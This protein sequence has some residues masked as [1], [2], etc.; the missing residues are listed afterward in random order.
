MKKSIHIISAIVGTILLSAAAEGPRVMAQAPDLISTLLTDY[1]WRSIGPGAAGGRITDVEALDAD[2]RFA[3]AAAASGG[4]WKTTNAGTTWTPIFDHYGASSIGDIAI[5]QKD[6]RILW[7]GTGEANN[8]NSVAWGDGIYKSSDGGQTFQ[9][10]GLKD[11]FQ[12]ARVVTHPADPDIVYVAAVG[13]LWGYTGDRGVFKT[14]DG[15]R[16]WQKLTNGLPNDGKSGATD[17]A[18]DPGNPE[19]LYAA[20]YQ[21]LRTPW[22]FDSGGPNGGI[23]KTTDGG[24]TW[25]KLTKG[26]PA[27]DTGRIGINV[28]RK[29][30]KIIMAIVEHGFRPQRGS[31]EYADMTKLGSGIYRSEDGGESWQYLNRYNNRPF[32]YSQIRINPSDDQ[33]VYV[34][35]TSFQ[36]S[37]DGGKTF[38]QAPA[39]FG[40]NYDHHAMWI[41]PAIKDRFYLGD[42]KGLALTHDHG[43]TFIFFDNLPIAQFYKVNADLREPYA[44]YGGL[45]DN[46]SWATRSFTRDAL[47]IRN[48]AAWKMHWDD[49]QYVAIDPTDWRTVYSEGTQGSFRVVDPISHTDTARRATPRNIVNFQERTGKDPS[50]PD[51]SQ[52]LRFNWTT[53]FIISPHDPKVVYYGTNYLLKTTDKGLTWQIVSPDLTKND[54]ARNQRGSGGLTPENTGAEAYATI[55]SIS[56]SPVARG[57]IWAGTDDGNV[58]VTRDGG[59]NWTEVDAAIPDVPKGLCVSRVA[60]SAVDANTAYVSFDGHRSDNRAAWLFRTTDGGKTWVSL[61]AGLAPG[62]PVYV[63]EEDA[64]NP[65]LLFV[66]TEFGLQ[67]SLDRGHSWRPM[68]NGLP[69]VAV[70]DIVIH[71]RDRDV[72]IGTHGRGIY[73]L[74]DITALEEW[75][76]A[77]A[78]KP[79]HLFVQRPATIWE[80]Q[81]RTGQMGDNTYAGQNP[82]YVQQINLAQRDRTHLVN[83]PLITFYLGAGATGTA[84]VEITSPDGRSRKLAVPARPGIIRYAWD[85]RFDGAAGGTPQGQR[86]GRGAGGAGAT[87]SESG[88]QRGAGTARPVPGTYSLRLTLGNSTATGTLELRPDPLL[89]Q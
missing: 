62:Q 31:P 51:A 68:M 35:T 24:R 84:T 78:A 25:Q 36:W 75:R 71:P 86:G 30:P 42:D 46:G 47:G 85:G 83:T 27:G 54:P 59:A 76:P 16:T 88:G 44:V 12:I 48:D 26:L 45:Q 89:K 29:N 81:S 87:A 43:A 2:F 66:G 14:V 19:V 33:L 65:D 41:D 11:T 63:V 58:W 56:E 18:M 60:A 1:K 3:I 57:L 77:L 70:Y 10:A 53:P 73:I 67:V 79:A 4:V 8:R 6:P 20:F 40:P 28:Y 23:F 61:S 49:G 15:G 7:V 38:A 39:P 50:A 64:R 55:Y 74:D 34:L 82:P 22:R 32:Y 80:D 5:F 69:T 17:L 13:N 37:K 9:N 72:I 52:A 21:R